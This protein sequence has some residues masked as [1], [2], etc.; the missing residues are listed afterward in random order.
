M[1]RDLTGVWA[2]D[3]GGTYYLQT[4]G[5]IVWWLGQDDG[6][7]LQLGTS[8]TNIFRGNVGVS[9]GV[10]TL[11]EGQWA[12]VPRGQTRNFGELALSIEYDGDGNPVVLRRILETGGFGGSTWTFQSQDVDR[13][14]PDIGHLFRKDHQEHLAR[15]LV[16]PLGLGRSGP[17]NPGR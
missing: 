3:D 10:P 13:S 8:F 12:D 15:R 1:A 16:R 14:F 4:A 17:R 11:L 2:A 9:A 7:A 5:S 6:G